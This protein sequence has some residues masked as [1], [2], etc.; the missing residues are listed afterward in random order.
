[1]TTTRHRHTNEPHD[2]TTMKPNRTRRPAARALVA[3]TLLSGLAAACGSDDSANSIQT[4]A[5]ATSAVSTT[6]TAGTTDPATTEPAA[7]EPTTTEPTTTEPTTTEPTA[8]LPTIVLVHGAFANPSSWDPV[9][10]RLRD[11]GFEVVTPVNPL[12]GPT[13]DAVAV[14]AALDEIGGDVIV[15]GHSYGGIPISN[16]ATGDPNVRA[17]VYV[18]AYVPDEGETFSQIQERVP[19]QLT[20]DRLA[21]GPYTTSDGTESVGATINVDAFADV[22]AADL[23]AEQVSQLAAA[24]MPLDVAALSDPSGPPAWREI[25]SWYLIATQD[26]IIPPELARTMAERAGA[27]LEEIDASHAVL[28]SQPAAV[29][30]LISRV[31]HETT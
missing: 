21:I 17:L 18:A 23:P 16:A 5:P 15:V 20:P 9:V 7:T 25:P 1:M 30:D 22:F 29:A 31:A 13:I 8:D 3:F 24:Q 11:E 10:S 6:A 28:L 27:T 12:R 26:Q 19:G 4:S 2:W 14:R